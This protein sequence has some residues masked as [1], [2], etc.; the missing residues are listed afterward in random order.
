MKI[1]DVVMILEPAMGLEST[2]YV[3]EIGI[4]K[5]VGESIKSSLV[6]FVSPFTGNT[7]GYYF[8]NTSLY[9]IGTL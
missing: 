2:E 8:Y 1:H 4:V 3:G 9:K 5:A 6:E 7:L